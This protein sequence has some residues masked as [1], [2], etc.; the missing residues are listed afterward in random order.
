M[1]LSL[2]GKF[3]PLLAAVQL[4]VGNGV[5]PCIGGIIR[6]DRP[7]AAYKHLGERK[8]FQ[9]VGEVTFVEEPGERA[10]RAGAV[11]VAPRWAL[12]AGHVAAKTDPGKQRYTFGNEQYR[13]IRRVLHP[14]FKPESTDPETRLATTAAGAD[15]ALVRLDRPVANIRP[16]T[17]YR[18]ENEVGQTMTKVGYGVI[19]NGLGRVHPA[20][21]KRRGGNNVIDAAGAK[22]GHVT[23]SERVLL[24]DFDHP[25]DPTLNRLGTSIPLELEIGGSP[26]DSG[27]G[28]FIRDGDSW[29]LVGITSGVVPPTGNPY[30]GLPAFYGSIGAGMRVSKANDWIDDVI[31]GVDRGH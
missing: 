16:A 20:A 9:C 8:A 27:A 6:H 10:G 3:V 14:G 25:N 22:F 31:N 1:R 11:L 29:K 17:R 28:W 12:T 23:Y 19:G 18:G 26:G 7:A 15:L 13:A 2:N 4:V 5:N 21:Q 30:D 24:F